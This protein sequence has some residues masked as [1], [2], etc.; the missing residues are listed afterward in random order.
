MVSVPETSAKGFVEE[1][2]EF[3]GVTYV[4]QPETGGAEELDTF[5]KFTGL[6]I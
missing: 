3:A 2:K 4:L 1:F 6:Q 5:T